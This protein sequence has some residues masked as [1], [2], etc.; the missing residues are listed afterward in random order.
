[1]SSSK[2]SILTSTSII[3]GSSVVVIFLKIISS[4]AVA[5]ILGPTGTGLI[6]ALQSSTT[7]LQTVSSLGINN[8]AVRDIAQANSKDNSEQLSITIRS[9][10]KAVI[11]TGLL[12]LILTF[13]FAGLLSQFTFG[14]QEYTLE[15]RILS[16]A[17]FFNLIQ[18]GQT[19]LIQGMRR[20][21]DLAKMSI[22]SALLV[23]L[24]SLPVLYT[25]ELDGVVYFLLTISIGQYL[26]SSYFARKI[27]I[28]DLKVSWLQAYEE[29]KAMINLGF[30]FMGGALAGVLGA[31][32][33][34]VMII[35]DLSLA[36]AGIYQAAFAISGL[37]IGIILKAMG[38]DFYPRL[39]GVAFQSKEEIQLINEQTQVGML[40]AAPGLMFTLALAPI[41][42]ELL[43]SAEYLEAYPVLQWMILGVFLRTISWPM[44]FLFVAR[45][46]GVVF[47][48][49]EIISWTLQIVLVYFG[50]QFFG[51]VGTGVAFFILY[52]FYT[53]MMFILL[54]RE[55]DFKWSSQVVKTIISMSLVFT[56]AFVILQYMS[57]L[58]GSIIV[59][60]LGLILTY[61]AY[62]EI[63]KI[64]E[65]ENIKDLIQKFKRKRK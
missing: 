54:N 26:V 4:K 48:W 58:W 7:M 33:V 63:A 50:L 46:K 22:F 51:L 49:T 18:G 31:Y 30:S 25:Y 42:I 40:L 27:K 60:S 62:L 15:I 10:R 45:A 44:G 37:Y 12:G 43:Y 20:I 55:N 59:C 39:T 17:V 41:G 24:V 52:I 64:L 6:G 19:A 56:L 2:K 3:G 34:R 8:S 38:K 61:V 53:I 28:K 21:K 47:F 23:T 65:I 13:S 32:L 14:S 36:D 16:V 57:Q 5:L 9:L 35:R 29:S 1:L 11:F